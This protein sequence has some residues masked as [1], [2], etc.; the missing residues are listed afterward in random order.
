M[1][2]TTEM[3]NTLLDEGVYNKKQLS[4]DEL[5]ISRPTLYTRL[6]GKSEWKKLEIKWISVLYDNYVLESESAL[7]T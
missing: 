4:I 5:G 6:E 3:V 7:K 1:K 2:S